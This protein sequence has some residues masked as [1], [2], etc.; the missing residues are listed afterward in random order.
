MRA[1]Q[2]R[3]A[4]LILALVLLV[5]PLAQAEAP[6]GAAASLAR[7][8]QAP[9]PGGSASTGLVGNRLLQQLVT[10]LAV[11][12]TLQPGGQWVEGSAEEWQAAA[13][14]QPLRAGDRVRTDVTGLA[15]LVF[16]DGS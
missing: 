7:A 8:S 9:G 11:L 2:L 1:V 15:R 10:D 13:E 4:V 14:R 16:A 6:G 5:I 12:E 3:R